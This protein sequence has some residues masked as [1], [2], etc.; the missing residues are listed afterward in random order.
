MEDVV[1]NNGNPEVVEAEIVTKLLQ[2][3]VHMG[4][5]ESNSAGGRVAQSVQEAVKAQGGKTRLTT[6]FTTQNK[7][8]KIIM[9]SPF[10]KEHFLFKDKTVMKEKEYRGFM[11]NVCSWTM[12]GKAKHDDGPDSL[13]MLADYVQCFAMSMPTIF[14]RPF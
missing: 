1:F 9:A 10:V 5:F 14:Q 8:T 6:K 2:H 7:E 3:K 12:N 13:A 4:R 11:N